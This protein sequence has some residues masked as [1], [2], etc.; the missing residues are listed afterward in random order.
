MLIGDDYPWSKLL[1]EYAM[2]CSVGCLNVAVFFSMYY[3]LYEFR[4][5]ESYPAASAWAISYFLS[6]ILA[7]YLHRWLTFESMTG[8]GKSLFVMLSIYVTLLVISTISTA[9]FADILGFNHYY[10]WAVNTAAFGF[11]SFILLRIFA[12][13]LSDGRIT[14][15]ERLEEFRNRRRA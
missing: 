13:P 5:S 1:R 11:A 6:S 4:I 12:F 8:Y 3:T 9:Y 15:K 7:H 14:R 10:S 2:Y